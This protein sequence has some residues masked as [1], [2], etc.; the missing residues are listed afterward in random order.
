MNLHTIDGE[1][2]ELSRVIKAGIAM[3]DPTEKYCDPSAYEVAVA[4]ALARNSVAGGVARTTLDLLNFPPNTEVRPS[5]LDIGAGTGLLSGRLSKQGADVTATDISQAQL[6]YI[7]AHNR[8]SHTEILDFNK[9]FGFPNDHF[10]G[11]VTLAANRYIEK[12]LDFAKEVHRILKPEGVFV[13]PFFW[14]DNIEFIK[15]QR[16]LISPSGFSQ[17]L[18]DVGFRDHYVSVQDTIKNGALIFPHWAAP[19]YVIGRK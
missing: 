3:A 9:P 16:G 14:Q 13:W 8:A 4:I 6:D 17:I 18:G 7:Q 12:L 1:P 19:V 15:S 5:I 2:V 11:V 10:H